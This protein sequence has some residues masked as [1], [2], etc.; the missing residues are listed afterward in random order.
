[1]SAV[2]QVLG[3]IFVISCVLV[4]VF[5]TIRILLPREVWTHVL[6]EI[7]TQGLRGLWRLVVILCKGYIAR[8]KVIFKLLERIKRH[9]K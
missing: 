7:I 4:G 1:M 9:K 2:E 5:L 8:R 6:A 3:I